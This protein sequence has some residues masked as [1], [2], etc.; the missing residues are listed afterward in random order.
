MRSAVKVGPGLYW[1]AVDIEAGGWRLAPG[2]G[3]RSINRLMYVGLAFDEIARHLTPKPRT[4]D[5]LMAQIIQ[6]SME[7][8][9][10]IAGWAAYMFPNPA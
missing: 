3:R 2:G 9:R 1:I 4:L 6:R 10:R 5:Q 7:S 8:P